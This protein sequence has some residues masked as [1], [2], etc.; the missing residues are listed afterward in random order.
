MTDK[1]YGTLLTV[2]YDGTDFSGWQIQPGQRTV[3]GVLHAAALPMAGSL[4]NLRGCSRTD[5]GVHAL[6]QEVSFAS[7]REIRPDGWLRGL[8]RA[9]PDDVAVQRAEAC[10]ADYDPRR[11]VISKLY[12][13]TYRISQARNPLTRKRAWHIGPP[14]ALPHPP[15]SADEW[16][17]E[18]RKLRPNCPAARPFW[19]P[20]DHL[21]R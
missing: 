18:L 4:S 10:E 3:Q 9:L 17:H 12:R 5:S 1:P 21:K 2:A 8:N 6:G 11:D 13:Y 15:A 14:L 16:T 7:A 19:Q 20:R